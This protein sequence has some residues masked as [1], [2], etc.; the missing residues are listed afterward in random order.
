MMA[1]G[2]ILYGFSIFVTD[3]AAGARFSKTTLSLAYG[4]SVVVGGV[5]AF[6]VGAWADRRGVRSIL[7]A[8]GVC[9]AAGMAAFGAAQAPWQVIA[10]WW[11]L[12][13]PASALLFYEV[14]F[15]AL[16][17]WC[18]PQD[19]PRAL[20]LVTLIGGLAGIIFIPGTEWLVTVIG[21]RWTAALLGSLV[22]GTAL[23]TSVGLSRQG[24]LPT[25]QSRPVRLQRT[26]TRLLGDRR[27]TI[28][29]AA[30]VLV[31]FSV[32]GL[33]A[34]RV[35]VF[36][37]S[38]FDLQVVAVWAALAS[39]LSLP[40]RWI[41]PLIATRLGAPNL[42]AVTTAILSVA[43]VVMLGAGARWQ[44]A[45]HFV[46]FGLAFGAFLP[47]RAMTMSG[48]FSGQSYGATMGS[49]WTIVTVL[50]ALGPVATGLLRDATGS[51]SIAILALG[52]AL[53]LA[54]AL[55]LVVSRLD[56]PRQE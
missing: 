31:F 39:A 42:Q 40:G 20:G 26:Q 2:V 9:A 11:L 43:T 25:G 52:T 38:G 17:Q 47:L 53:A 54:V 29:T 51:Y 41:A 24:V 48:W 49:Q 45:G 10:A 56:D 15:I 44:M 35:A 19:R 37:E 22:L 1:F 16:D 34:H 32:Q 12:I 27:F 5:L 33:F 23:L 8:G 6:P 18:T 55:L 36:E 7:A 21:W 13:G 28:H 46:L 14:A 50:G 3:T 4:G 30:M